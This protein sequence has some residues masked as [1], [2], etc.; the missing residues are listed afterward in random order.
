MPYRY[1]LNR[2]K[3]GLK[4]TLIGVL[5]NMILAFVKIFSGIIGHSYALIADGIESTTDVFSSVVV[6][7]GIRIAARPPD[8]N[9]PF[10]HGK[11]E[12]LAAMVV[13]LALIGAAVG[14]IIQSVREIITPHHAPAPF[15]LIVLVVVIVVKELL[16]RFAIKIGDEL[17]SLSIQADAWHHRSDAITSL[18]AFLGI[19]V[20]LVMGRGYEAADDVGAIIACLIIFYNGWRI[21]CRSLQ[22]V[23]DAAPTDAIEPIVR[24]IAHRVDGVLDVEKCQIRKSGFD[25]FVEIHIEVDGRITVDQGHDIACAVKSV[26]TKSNPNI[27]NVIVHV[28][29][30]GMG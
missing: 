12:A 28:E 10:G 22:E 5:I 9:H 27:L 24:E 4:A 25:Y 3:Q 30:H 7:S 18:A 13:G 11:A 20:A 14:M 23:M 16:F 8:D 21:F 1:R 6:Y 15:T 29:P 19:S 2:V 17:S 26:L